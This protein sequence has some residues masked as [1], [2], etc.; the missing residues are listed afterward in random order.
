M[1]LLVLGILIPACYLSSLSLS[2]PDVAGLTEDEEHS[3]TG[4]WDNLMQ[5]LY[6]FGAGQR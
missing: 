5:C 2:R 4:L 1:I 3:L 6:T